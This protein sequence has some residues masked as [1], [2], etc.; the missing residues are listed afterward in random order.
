MTP[1]TV[2]MHRDEEEDEIE[3]LLEQNIKLTKENNKLLRKLWRAEV[4]GFW[5]RILFIAILIGIPVLVYQ[6]FLVD[7]VD[8]VR[9][10]LEDVRDD[11]GKIREIPD[12]I[13]LP[14]IIGG[15]K[16]E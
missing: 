5:S 15:T 8:Q 11:L 16:S 14:T 7:Y 10:T 3:V 2:P 12:K 6:Y 13:S 9:T 4:M 1:Y